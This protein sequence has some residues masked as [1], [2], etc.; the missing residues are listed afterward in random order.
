MGGEERMEEDR[1]ESSRQGEYRGIEE[2]LINMESTINGIHMDQLVPQQSFDAYRDEN[3]RAQTQMMEMLS[4]ME[5]W[6]IAQG[7][8][9]APPPP[10]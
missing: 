3:Q 9:H 7:H 1:P 8:Y 5:Q 2:R 10:Q 6:H 4:R